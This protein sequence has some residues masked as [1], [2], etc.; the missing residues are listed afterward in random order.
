MAPKKKEPKSTKVAAEGPVSALPSVGKKELYLQKEH[1]ALTEH[2]NVCAQRARQFQWESEFLDKEAQQIRETSKVY[3]SYLTRR[4]VRRQNAIVSLNDQNRVDLARIKQQKAELVAQY[5][6]REKAVRHQ[7]LERE[8]KLRLI[9]KEAEAMQAWREL[10][11][12]QLTRIRELEK[13]LLVMKVQHADQMHEVKSR[14]LQQVP[15][16]EMQAQQ[17]V[18]ALAKLAEKE[19]VRSLIQHTKQVKADNRQLR[20]ELLGLIRQAQV[21]KEFLLQLRGR[22]QQLLQEHQYRQ[23][24]ARARTWLRQHEPQLATPLGGSR[25]RGGR[26]ARTRLMPCQVSAGEAQL[27]LAQLSQL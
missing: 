17:K 13:E 12:E 23:D 10:Q 8:T 2:V 15:D 24:L 14:F 21:L 7:L 27:P 25:F 6:E 4:T 19:A 16:Y 22:R 11:L 3:L 5:T 18:Q 20:H 9:S 26:A 1:A